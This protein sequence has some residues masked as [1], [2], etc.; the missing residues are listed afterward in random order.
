MMGTNPRQDPR[1]LE[2]RLAHSARQREENQDDIQVML[3]SQV[4]VTEILRATKI[5]HTCRQGGEIPTLDYMTIVQKGPRRK[6]YWKPSK[7]H[8]ANIK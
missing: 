1:F 3:V 8:I 2:V 4:S 6:F 7:T 5:S